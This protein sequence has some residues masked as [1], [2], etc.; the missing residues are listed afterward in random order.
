[1]LNNTVNMFKKSGDVITRIMDAVTE[2]NGS[3]A[4]ALYENCERIGTTYSGVIP[5]TMSVTELDQKFP[6]FSYHIHK[7][8]SLD[9]ILKQI[10][11]I[12]CRV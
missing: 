10:N 5:E 7:I 3:V 11:A 8:P 1:M 4:H 2:R 6:F 12:P 9:H